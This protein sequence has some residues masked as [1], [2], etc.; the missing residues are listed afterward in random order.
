[1]LDLRCPRPEP[2]QECGACRRAKKITGYQRIGRLVPRNDK[3]A[4]PVLTEREKVEAKLAK[5]EDE[6]RRLRRQLGDD[7]GGEK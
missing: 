5:A 6:V 7:V 1:M 4:R 3:P 2:E